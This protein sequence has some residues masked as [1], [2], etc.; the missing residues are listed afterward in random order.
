[1]QERAIPIILEGRNALIIAATASGKTEAAMAPLLERHVLSESRSEAALRILYLCPTKA[2]VR[3]LYERLRGPLAQLNV[4]LGMKSGDT[5]P[6]SATRPPIALITT[7]ESTDSLLTRAPRVLAELRAVVLDEIH[8]FD[9]GPRG[10]HLQCL[11]RRIERVRR[12]RQRERGMERFRPLQRV[13]LSATVPHPAGV[14]RRYLVGEDENRAAIIEAPG[15]RRLEAE[16]VNMA[17]LSDLVGALARRA[18]GALAARKSL[19]FCNT[20]NEVEQT[21]AYLR[22]HLP[23]AASVFVHY[24]NID[25]AMRKQVEE[26]FARAGVAICVSSSTLELGIDIGSIDDVA[27]IGPPPTMTSFLQRIGRGGRRTGL[28]RVLCLARSEPERA[29]FQAMIELARA[30]KLSP[31]HLAQ[32]LPAHPRFRPSVLVQQVFSILKQSPTAAIRLA[33]LRR[34]APPDIDDETLARILDHLTAEDYLRPGRLGEWR[35]GP[36]LTELIDAHEIYSNIGAGP[37]NILIL[38][39]FTGRTLA[40]TDRPRFR[41]EA[42]LMGGRAVEVVWRDRYRIAVRPDARAP[43]DEALSFLAAPLT[44]P[45]E[46]S[47]AVAMHMGLRARELALLHHDEET[48]LFHFWGD[49]YGV[50]LAGILDAHFDAEESVQRLNEHALRLPA[51]L[52]RLPDWNPTIV[53][54]QIA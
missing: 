37:R 49:L 16:L 32:T 47:Q 27:L 14:A 45:L 29:R 2:L 11:L 33:D 4:S 35:A 1:M 40:Q 41:G 22:Q 44:V 50:L 19:I 39:A 10:D 3:D 28:T 23:Y 43:A 18:G 54:R 9:G 38:D 12:Y 52:S 48:M 34:V 8:L 51:P 6:V 26:D 36:A 17:G 46:I 53:R 31:D 30:N 42:L 13:A 20:R 25:P 7:P 21:A 15:S 24:S 5:G